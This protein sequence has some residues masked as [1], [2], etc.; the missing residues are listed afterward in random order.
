[1]EI[2]I[3]IRARGSRSTAFGFVMFAGLLALFWAVSDTP[4]VALVWVPFAAI[5]IR[6]GAVRAWVDGD[7]LRVRNFWRSYDLPRQEIVRFD[8]NDLRWGQ[9]QRARAVEVV[10][11]YRRK[12]VRLS[13]TLFSYFSF[14]FRPGPGNYKHNQA[15]AIAADLNAWLHTGA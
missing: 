7:R 9:A 13:A 14:P 5:A 1:M 4:Q 10:V 11:R 15:D 6:I 12:R 3:D 8:V 2:G